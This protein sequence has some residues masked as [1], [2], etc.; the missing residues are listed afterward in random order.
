[1][2]LIS[3]KI[4][5]PRKVLHL[6]FLFVWNWF[7][8]LLNIITYMMNRISNKI[9]YTEID[10]FHLKIVIII[11]I[12]NSFNIFFQFY[13]LI[14]FIWKYYVKLLNN[15]LHCTNCFQMNYNITI[16]LLKFN[17]SVLE[18]NIYKFKEIY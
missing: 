3:D 9:K 6:K 13:H 11:T 2:N 15:Q 12:K 17:N 4:K 10:L 14:L 1:M 18:I 7:L 5:H 16:F 8:K